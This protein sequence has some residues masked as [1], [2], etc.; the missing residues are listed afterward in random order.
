MERQGSEEENI[1]C[2]A[3]EDKERRLHS[4]G[5]KLQHTGVA[6]GCSSERDKENVLYGFGRPA[7]FRSAAKDDLL[8]PWC[9][10]RKKSAIKCRGSNQERRSVAFSEVFYA[11]VEW[12]VELGSGTA[13]L[14]C[15]SMQLRILQTLGW[16]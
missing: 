1:A 2:T 3:L 4:L 13:C 8:Q 10:D 7:E 12:S 6:H 11:S 14:L 16:K 15:L 5:W 9:A